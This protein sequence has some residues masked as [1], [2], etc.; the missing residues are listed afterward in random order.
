M[1]RKAAQETEQGMTDN[2]ATQLAIL[3]RQRDAATDPAVRAALDS[4]IAALEAQLGSAVP[5]PPGDTISVGDVSQATGVAV[6]AGAQ[7]T[8]FQRGQHQKA[9]WI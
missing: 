8:V 5:P 3:R 4:A 7:S 6:G 1:T 9:C 2:P